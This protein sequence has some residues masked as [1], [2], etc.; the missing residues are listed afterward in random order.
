MLE[1]NLKVINNDV[2]TLVKDAQS[3]FQSAAAMTGEKAEE[4]HKRGMRMLD[5]ALVK[6]Q[7]AQASALVTSKEMAAST[8]S[9]VKENP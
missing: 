4:V 2:K 5:T 6:V 9:Y 3:L 8:E 1:A 7:D